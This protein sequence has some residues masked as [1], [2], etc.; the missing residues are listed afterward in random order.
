MLGSFS[1]K[2]P[3]LRGLQR[4][5]GCDSFSKH[6]ELALT[7]KKT[8]EGVK[9]QCVSCLHSGIQTTYI[10]TFSS[11]HRRPEAK[12]GWILGSWQRLNSLN[13]FDGPE[14]WF[15]EA[16]TMSQREYF[17]VDSSLCTKTM[18]HNYSRIADRLCSY[19]WIADQRDAQ[20][21]NL[22]T[23]PTNQKGYIR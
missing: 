7:P 8:N 4:S 10:C 11:V 14:T 6:L 19:S 17:L 18:L 13:T 21:N 2:S 1:E 12:R 3:V 9:N 16:K 5:E 20:K 22:P 15:L 23:S